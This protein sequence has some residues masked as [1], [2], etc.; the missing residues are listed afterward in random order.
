[1]SV[2][3]ELK[4][5]AANRLARHRQLVCELSADAIES[6]PVRALALARDNVERSAS[7][8]AEAWKNLLLRGSVA[9]ICALLRDTNSG[10]EQMRISQPFAGL[11]SSEQLRAISREAYGTA[12]PPGTA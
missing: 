1:M 6:A 4:A 11:L 7:S 9:E 10:S 3:T 12:A 8:F 5:E 2:A